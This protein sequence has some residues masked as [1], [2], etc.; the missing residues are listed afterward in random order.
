MKNK[1]FGTAKYI[2][3]LVVFVLL[4]ALP[5]GAYFAFVQSLPAQRQA[6]IMGSVNYKINL[7]KNTPGPRLILAGGSS[8]PYATNCEYLAKTL[9]LNCINV[10]AT[11]YLGIEF[12]LAML[13]KHMQPKDII[14]IGPEHSMLMGVI[15]YSTVWSALENHPN[16][17]E[18]IPSSYLP[19]LAKDYYRYAQL[20]LDAFSTYKPETHD[21]M[22]PHF[23]PL[24]DVT[25]P[26]TPLLESGYNTQDPISLAP[27]IVN[28]KVVKLLN[29][30]Y[31]RATQKNVQVFFAF[32]PVNTLAITSTKQEIAAFEEAIKTQ[33]HMPIIVPLQNAIL[34]FEY[35]YD[36]NNHLT[37]AGAA[38]YSAGLASAL[39]KVL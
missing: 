10:G 36:S 15:H 11:A 25:L 5:F 20:K 29:N 21:L 1:T 17:W 2:T 32:A 12:Y 19:G 16:V 24:G 39:Q 9:N 28:P 22:H 6:T 37:T 38:V 3:K 18:I 35:F 14:V 27:G 30:F 7:L 31:A 4:V 26:R 33:L 13:Q 8:S 34:P 23:G